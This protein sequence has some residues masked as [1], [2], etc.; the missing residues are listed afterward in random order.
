MQGSGRAWLGQQ[1]ASTVHLML[2]PMLRMAIDGATQAHRALEGALAGLDDAAARRPCLLDGW[3]VG[4]LLAHLARNA[5]SHVRVLEGARRGERVAQYPG[6]PA[7]RAGDIDA[8]SAHPASVLVAEVLAADRALETCWLSFDEWPAD[9]GVD[10]IV[11]RRWREVEV[12]HADL[13]PAYGRTYRDWS[14]AY[15]RLELRT[16]TMLWDSRRP[17]G[18]T[19]LP[20]AVM[21]ADEPER[22]A[23]LLGRHG[24]D[25]VEP[26]GLMP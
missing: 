12:H 23:W 24:I 11:L 20:A 9:L 18:L 19:G 21:A 7:Q 13:G 25:G 22:L 1:V 17:M 5:E 6:G 3:S 4:H 10:D 16:L 26:A 8:G 15:L 2:D 14:P